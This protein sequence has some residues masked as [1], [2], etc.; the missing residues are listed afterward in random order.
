MDN[1]CVMQTNFTDTAALNS[2]S[3]PSLEYEEEFGVIKCSPLLPLLLFY[4]SF[5][6]LAQFRTFSLPKRGGGKLQRVP[7]RRVV[8]ERAHTHLIPIFGSFVS[9][10]LIPFAIPNARLLAPSRK[11]EKEKEKV[12]FI[13]IP[14]YCSCSS[15]SSR[16]S[17]P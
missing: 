2:S 16:R 11:K 8:L 1:P 10:L 14:T 9:A 5:V 3:F 6:T 7:S 15:R 13:L 4:Q 12:F 17:W